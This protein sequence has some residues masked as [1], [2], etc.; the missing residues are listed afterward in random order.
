MRSQTA[1]ICLILAL[2]GPLLSQASSA[3]GFARAISEVS[4]ANLFMEGEH[5]EAEAFDR[6]SLI[7][8]PIVESEG[9]GHGFAPFGFETPAL[10]DSFGV[11]PVDSR[12]SR[13]SWWRSPWPPP[14]AGRRH[15]L[16]QVFLF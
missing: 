1:H 13:D 14:S 6:L 2:G 11:L 9:L 12:A 4:T 10:F 8:L 16:L 15:A 3:A 7:A 5:E